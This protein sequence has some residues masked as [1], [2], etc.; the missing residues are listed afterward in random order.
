MR[1][2]FCRGLGPEDEVDNGDDPLGQVVGK[3]V[4]D[5]RIDHVLIAWLFGRSGRFSGSDSIAHSSTRA[6]SP[7]SDNQSNSTYDSERKSHQHA[8]A[9]YT[10]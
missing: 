6:S 4:A 8:Q 10:S 2:G 7:A 1:E 3:Q 5:A 9:G